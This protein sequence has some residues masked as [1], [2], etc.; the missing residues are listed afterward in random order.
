MFIVFGFLI[1]F[2][3]PT[4]SIFKNIHY[5]YVI[6]DLNYSNNQFINIIIFLNNISILF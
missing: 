3:I 2:T 5:F 6:Y 4:K 1:N